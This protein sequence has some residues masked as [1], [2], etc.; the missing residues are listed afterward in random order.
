MTAGQWT[1]YA[2]AALG[3]LGALLLAVKSRYSGW[4]FVLWLA[5][6]VLWIIFGARGPHWGLV[7]QNLVFSI[8]SMIG[9]YVWLLRPRWQDKQREIDALI[10]AHTRGIP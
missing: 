3:I 7:L 9:I 1:E 5:S 4:A 2:G 6:N 10:D 8:T